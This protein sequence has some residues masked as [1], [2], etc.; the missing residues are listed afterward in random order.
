[1]KL[2]SET[3]QADFT[4]HASNERNEERKT[5]LK[6]PAKGGSLITPYYVEK[7][8]GFT[9]SLPV[10]FTLSLKVNQ[11]SFSLLT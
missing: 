3:S 1:M 5:K 2:P 9:L 7:T 6:L 4:A 10:G 8:L 11:K